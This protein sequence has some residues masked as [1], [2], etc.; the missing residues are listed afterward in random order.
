MDCID[1]VQDR[2]SGRSL[3]K[4]EMNLGVAYNMGNSLTS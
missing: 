2:D 1:L 3:V 4:A